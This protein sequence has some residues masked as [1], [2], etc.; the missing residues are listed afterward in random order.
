MLFKGLSLLMISA[1][2]LA[3]C[4]MSGVNGKDHCDDEFKSSTKLSAG[5]MASVYICMKNF[6][7]REGAFKK[8]FWGVPEYS[9]PKTVVDYM[10][11]KL[12]GETVFQPFSAYSGLAEINEI[13]ITTNDDDGFV[14]RVVGGDGAGSY[15]AAIEFDNTAKIIRKKVTQSSFPDDV[16]EEVNYS[17]FK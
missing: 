5:G 15:R 1:F 2:F 14:V 11:I 6:P 17:F 12:G 4:S 8:V 13:Q 9:N 16:W 3:S 7:D 10:D